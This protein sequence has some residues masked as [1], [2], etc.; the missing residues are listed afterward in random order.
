MNFY[1]QT[2]AQLE[3][4]ILTEGLRAAQYWPTWYTLTSS[5]AGA[6][7][8][9]SAGDVVVEIKLSGAQVREYLWPR[10]GVSEKYGRQ[11]ALRK[12]IP[13]DCIVRVHR[14]GAKS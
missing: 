1:H 2:R 5:L 4:G 14:I 12:P 8:Y 9:G 10:P 7:R 6:K 13:A 11:W 3:D